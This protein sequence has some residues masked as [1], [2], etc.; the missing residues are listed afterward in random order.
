MRKK[1]VQELLMQEFDAKH[2]LL[3]Y[4]DVAE[5]KVD[6]WQHYRA[7]GWREVRR[8]NAWFD[9][10]EYFREHPEIQPGRVDAFQHYLTSETKDLQSEE[11]T[12]DLVL[13]VNM[14]PSG[15]SNTTK[16]QSVTVAQPAMEDIIVAR[17]AFDGTYYREKNPDVAKWGG[18]PL[19][20]FLTIGWIEG[21]DPN[22]DFSLGFYIRHNKDMQSLKTNPFLHYLRH[23]QKERWR[24]SASVAEAAVLDSFAEDPEML[25]RV[26]QACML[27]PM[28]ALPDQ[29]RK[30]TSPALNAKAI[31]DAVTAIRKEVGAS[32]Y[33]YVVL[34][35]HIRMSGA[36]RVA[37]I[38]T[39]TMCD[40]R[41]PEQILL[42]TTDSDEEEYAFWFP[43]NLKR[44][45]L[46]QHVKALGPEHKAACLLDLLRGIDCETIFNIN[47]RLAWETMCLY[48]RQV[49][50][51]FRVITYL[52]TWDI[53]A[54]GARVGYP[55]QWLRDTADFHHLLL[56]DNRALNED[57][58]TRLSYGC[59]PQ[60]AEVVTL[61]TP[62]AGI[63]T[64]LPPAASKTSPRVLWAGRFDRQKRLDLLVR[65]ARANPHIE[66]DVYGKAVLDGIKLIDLQPPKNIHAKGT[67][68]NLET[69]LQTPYA[70]YLYTSQWDG[71]PTILLDIGQ[72]GL[73]IV[74]SNV[75]GVSELINTDSGW[76]VDDIEDI[77]AYS[78]ALNE[79][80]GNRSEAGARCLR[81]QQRIATK[82]ST[83]QYRSDLQG[84][85]DR[86]GI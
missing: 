54:R 24:R 56:T 30:V 45:N 21:R 80:V 60:D 5:A 79:I 55:V 72:T 64:R 39:N 46:S 66:F 1:R 13:G 62:G 23:G 8:P 50:Q 11:N 65:I 52:F 29:P 43:D 42:V 53:S 74:A 71:I 10:E 27:D 47:S 44:I 68:T 78:N 37:S 82:F 12:P 15:L 75:G 76:L 34:L 18:D 28:V 20:H 73:P 35:P 48:G 70:A 38:L 26:Q 57:I 69:V 84:V 16:E 31:A 14:V 9:P 7:Q 85:L 33:R 36:A 67:Y 22:P 2:Y 63:E 32:T 41:D 86:Y 83:S 40:I 81:L 4:P 59:T 25:G 49:S 3:L 6:P 58:C 61:Y 19:L 51:E 17:R 77:E